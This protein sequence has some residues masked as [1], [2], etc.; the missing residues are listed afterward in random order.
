M[1]S[2]LITHFEN[3][4]ITNLGKL[5]IQKDVREC[6]PLE[7]AQCGIKGVPVSTPHVAAL[8]AGSRSSSRSLGL[9]CQEET[10]QKITQNTV[11]HYMALL[12]LP[13]AYEFSRLRWQYNSTQN[14]REH[15]R[16]WVVFSST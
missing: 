9:P 2:R 1:Q 16:E 6:P 7:V 8:N 12:S 14:T 13:F 10:S 15:M 5:G 3:E 11:F 4:L